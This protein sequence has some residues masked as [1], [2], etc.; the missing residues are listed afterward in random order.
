MELIAK[1]PNSFKH[2]KNIYLI[3]VILAIGSIYGC[4]KDV[5]ESTVIKA[6]DKL[7]FY[8]SK[9]DTIAPIANWYDSESFDINNDGKYDIRIYVS[10][11][12]APSGHQYISSIS[13]VDTT[14]Q[15]IVTSDSI[16]PLMLNMR[17]TLDCSRR[18][19][20]KPSFQLANDYSTLTN[21]N[22]SHYF[23]WNL[24][25]AYIGVRNEYKKGSYKF[26]WIKIGVQSIY[27]VKI[28]EYSFDK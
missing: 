28:F 27:N 14:F 19:L 6:G 15:F 1:Q 24:Q 9:I 23:Y 17:D 12:S 7:D 11:V 2:M 5:S 22:E 21:P 18:W 3:L 26:G 10:A 16:S 20:Y 25:T 4:E 8:C 13:I